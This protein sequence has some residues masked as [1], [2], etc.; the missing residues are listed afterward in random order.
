MS[1]KGNVASTNRSRIKISQRKMGKIKRQKQR[2][3]DNEYIKSKT[4]VTEKD[5]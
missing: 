2:G 5:K 4:K 1:K 3:K